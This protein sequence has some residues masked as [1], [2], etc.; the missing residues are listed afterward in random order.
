VNVRDDVRDG[1]NK[2][3]KGMRSRPD[4]DPRC[5]LHLLQSSI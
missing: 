5:H 3:D 2:K 1:V 4:D